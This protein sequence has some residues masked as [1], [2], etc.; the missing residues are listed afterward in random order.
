M[1]TGFIGN[2]TTNQSIIYSNSNWKVEEIN[3]GIEV[4]RSKRKR[5]KKKKMGNWIESQVMW[6]RGGKRQMLE[7]RL[8]KAGNGIS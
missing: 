4:H 6:K 1:H 3:I 8:K 5:K 2:L 7:I